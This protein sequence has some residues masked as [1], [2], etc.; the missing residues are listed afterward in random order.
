MFVRVCSHLQFRT[1]ECGT[2]PELEGRIGQLMLYTPPAPVG[3]ITHGYEQK[4]M[5]TLLIPLKPG[6]RDTLPSAPDW[7][8]VEQPV[9]TSVCIL[10]RPTLIPQLTRCLPRWAAWPFAGHNLA[11]G[12]NIISRAGPSNSQAAAQTTSV[13]LKP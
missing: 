1:R 2:K 10:R 5:A 11:C 8:C 13:L 3:H 9:G 4:H 7:A 12:F 6:R